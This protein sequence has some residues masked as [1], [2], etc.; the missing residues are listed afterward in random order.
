MSNFKPCFNEQTVRGL[1]MENIEEKI[2]VYVDL[3]IRLES[4]GIKKV[5][6]D[7]DFRSIKIAKD[8]TLADLYIKSCYEDSYKPFRKV[9]DILVNNKYYPSEIE[10]AERFDLYSKV[11]VVCEDQEKIVKGE[12]PWGLYGAYLLD[13]FAVGFANEPIED[14]AIIS[15]I[16]LMPQAV[17][18]GEEVY[19]EENVYN[20]TYAADCDNEK[21]SSFL[22]TKEIEAPKASEKD[23]NISLPKH[24]GNGDECKVH[25][26]SLIKDEYVVS[27][28]N[29]IKFNSD[30]RRYIRK[31][32]ADGRV[33][34]RMH[35]TTMGF[36]LCIQ[37]SGKDIVHTKWIARHLQRH[38]D[39][40]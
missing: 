10:K 12:F 38:F 4:Y 27:I 25:A 37:T 32:Y 11:E 35:W 5:L 29:S 14:H 36:G 8:L 2:R 13:S 16:R 23:T 21:F 31:V 39:H 15:R 20:I 30:E 28:I 6:Y 1:S 9:L 40:P 26:Q 34:V 18:E 3:L 24:H 22:A 19:E 7:T 17:K 33:E